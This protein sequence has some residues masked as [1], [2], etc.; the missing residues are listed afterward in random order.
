MKLK[1]KKHSYNNT[2]KNILRYT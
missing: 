1:I 2:S